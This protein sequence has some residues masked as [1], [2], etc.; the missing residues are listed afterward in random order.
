SPFRNSDVKL[1]IRLARR[2]YPKGN[3]SRTPKAGNPIDPGLILTIDSS[4]AFPEVSGASRGLEAFSARLFLHSTRRLPH[5]NHSQREPFLATRSQKHHHR[6]LQ[7][8]ADRV[9]PASLHL[10]LHRTFRIQQKVRLRRAP[11]TPRKPTRNKPSLLRP[12]DQP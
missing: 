4:Q 2:A 9:R 11:V 12:A 1:F 10:S 5:C 3:R 8:D 7:L 6:N